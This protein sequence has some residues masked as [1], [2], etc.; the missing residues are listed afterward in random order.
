MSRTWAQTGSSS[1]EQLLSFLNGISQHM[2]RSTSSGG[3][4]FDS[5]LPFTVY[6]HFQRISFSRSLPTSAITS[7]P[8]HT[9]ASEPA[10][11]CFV[12]VGLLA[13]SR[14]ATLNV[15][16]R[17]DIS[18]PSLAPLLGPYPPPPSWHG[19]S[20]KPETTVRGR[21]DR[22]SRFEDDSEDDGGLPDPEA[23]FEAV[24]I[25]LLACLDPDTKHP[26]GCNSSDPSLSGLKIPI[27]MV[28]QRG[29]PTFN[30]IGPISDGVLHDTTTLLRHACGKIVLLPHPPTSCYHLHF[31]WQPCTHWISATIDAQAASGVLIGK[32]VSRSL[33]RCTM[34][35]VSPRR[36][37]VCLSVRLSIKKV[38]PPKHRAAATYSRKK[39][40]RQM[41][42]HEAAG[43]ARLQR[44]N[45]E[46]DPHKCRRAESKSAVDRVQYHWVNDT[47]VVLRGQIQITKPLT[48]IM[49]RMSNAWMCDTWNIRTTAPI[50]HSRKPR[51]NY[52]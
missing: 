36:S 5:C 39:V 45:V 25:Q 16:A 52:N 15:P 10:L 14:R 18:D 21:S 30:S 27:V 51:P 35:S 20:I 11:S 37:S 44:M 43:R 3:I 34:Y 41:V 24:H 2:C 32:Q 12:L 9:I 48:Y 28:M 40:L 4:G 7:P 23:S 47:S 8:G 50:E 42:N 46:A 6:A 31:V 26:G 29:P 22:G 13:A 17:D 1:K 19:S 38:A 49:S 33:E